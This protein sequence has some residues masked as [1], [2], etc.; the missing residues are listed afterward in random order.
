MYSEASLRLGFCSQRLRW[1]SGPRLLCP[2][3]MPMAKAKSL[4]S[5]LF[6]PWE[7]KSPL[8]QMRNHKRSK[9]K[10]DAGKAWR[11]AS[12]PLPTLSPKQCFRSSAR[13]SLRS[14]VEMLSSCGHDIKNYWTIESNLFP[15][16]LMIHD[17]HWTVCWFGT[18]Y[19]EAMLKHESSKSLP[20]KWQCSIGFHSKNVKLQTIE[21]RTRLKRRELRAM[22]ILQQ[23]VMCLQEFCEAQIHG[24]QNR[25][26]F[27]LATYWLRVP[28][29][30]PHQLSA[31]Q[32]LMC[33][34]AALTHA[35]KLKTARKPWFNI[36]SACLPGRTL[37]SFSEASTSTWIN[38]STE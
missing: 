22:K 20:K 15:T 23:K 2:S 5:F 14:P 12:L 26:E 30:E 6:I 32:H 7:E 3:T 13:T 4:V 18:F 33:F 29:A 38:P 17:T 28:K 34:Q 8:V 19:V 21:S 31:L 1:R 16:E 35:E 10:R 11:Q 37:A 25:T 9:W 27:A 24:T 36:H